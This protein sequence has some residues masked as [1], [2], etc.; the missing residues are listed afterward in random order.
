MHTAFAPGKVI[1][2]GEHFVVHGGWALAAALSRG[3]T[4]RCRAAPRDRIRAHTLGLESD[5]ERPVPGPLRPIARVVRRT[6]EAFSAR[7]HV[8]LTLESDLP[9]ASGLGSSSS[10]AVAA[11]AATAAAVGHSVPPATLFELGMESERQIHGNPSGIDVAVAVH[12]GVLLYQRGRAPQVVVPR[13][14]VELVVAST[15]HQRRTKNLIRRVAQFRTHHARLFD[16]TARASSA[17][18]RRAADAVTSGDL[19]SLGAIMTMHH[20]ALTW[21]R[22]SSAR[23]DR[24]VGAALAAGA[25]G[26]KLTG[27]G[28]GGSIIALPAPGRTADVLSA[29]QAVAAHAFAV[30]LPA[31]GV[32][33]W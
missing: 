22:V 26:A 13:R 19:E 32:R 10:A 14:S 31:G 20:A 16:G 33:V 11:I 7:V 1:L 4:A 6:L 3:T 23:L 25:L 8:D 21:T 27:A 9:P 5:L 2:T 18:S 29:L 24:L 30:R 17:L 28:G 15:G 12:G